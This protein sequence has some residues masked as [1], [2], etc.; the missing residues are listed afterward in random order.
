MG[1]KWAFVT[2]NKAKLS[3]N[4]IDTLFFLRKRLF[5][6]RKLAK[7]EEIWDSNINPWRNTLTAPIL[8]YYNFT[9]FKLHS[10][11]VHMDALVD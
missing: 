3:Q 5:F 7:I 11:T 10:T 4:L 2:Q 1:E 9:I 8:H 6:R